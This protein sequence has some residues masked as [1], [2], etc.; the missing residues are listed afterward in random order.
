[1]GMED[2]EDGVD[3]RMQADDDLLQPTPARRSPSLSAQVRC[4]LLSR[5][6]RNTFSR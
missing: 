4:Y 5:A 1:M 3:R 6:S 2:L